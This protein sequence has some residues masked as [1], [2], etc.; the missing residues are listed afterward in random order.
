MIPIEGVSI[1]VVAHGL[2]IGDGVSLVVNEVL[3]LSKG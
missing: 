1:S 2:R 3:L